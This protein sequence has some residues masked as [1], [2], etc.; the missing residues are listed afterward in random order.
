MSSVSVDVVEKRIRGGGPDSAELRRWLLDKMQE[1]KRVKALRYSVAVQIRVRLERS[2]WR[3]SGDPVCPNGP[4]QSINNVIHCPT[5]FV[6][7]L[8]VHP[9]STERAQ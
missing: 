6:P 7:N 4:W 3:C 1:V 5:L 9:P 8:H 2:T